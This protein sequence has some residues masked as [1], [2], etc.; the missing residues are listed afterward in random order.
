MKSQEAEREGLFDRKMADHRH[1]SEDLDKKFSGLL[2]KQ[3]GKKP[4][5]PDFRDIDLD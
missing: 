2:K 3:K 5:R 1:R 4:S